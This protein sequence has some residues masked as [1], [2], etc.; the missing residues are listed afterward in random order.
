MIAGLPSDD[1]RGVT[2]HVLALIGPEVTHNYRKLLRFTVDAQ[3]IGDMRDSVR[4]YKHVAARMHS[5]H[6]QTCRILCTCCRC[7]ASDA[8]FTK[9]RLEVYVVELYGNLTWDV[10]R[11]N[12]SEG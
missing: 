4:I 5:L 8:P 10:S 6:V 9:L 1:S 11:W 12:T 2:V 3:P 7:Y